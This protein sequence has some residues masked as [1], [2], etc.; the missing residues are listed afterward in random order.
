MKGPF[1]N[2]QLPPVN[3]TL[4]QNVRLN[5]AIVVLARPHKSSRRFEHL[6]DHVI[7]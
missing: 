5:I 4:R 7:N 6:G 1:P 3:L 2:L